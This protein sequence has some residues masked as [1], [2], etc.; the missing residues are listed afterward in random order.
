MHISILSSTVSG[1]GTTYTA[2]NGLNLVGSA[3]SVKTADATKITVTTSGINL[4]TTGVTAGTYKSVTVDANG[5]VTGGT[6]PTTLA[7]YGITDAE[8]KLTQGALTYAATTS[9][10]F[11]SNKVQTLALTG[12]VTFTTSAK[13][14][15]LGVQVIITADSTAR[16]LTFPAGWIWLGTKPTQIAANKTGMLSLYCKGTAETDVIAGWGVQA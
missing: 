11:N 1:G 16:T 4:A 10:N 6:N 2:G 14:A 3:F 13:A 5:R 15:A 8:S 12:N 9:L 7:G